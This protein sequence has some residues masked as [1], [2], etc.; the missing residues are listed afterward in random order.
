MASKDEIRKFHLEESNH[1]RRVAMRLHIDTFRDLIKES[2]VPTGI[3]NQLC[4]ISLNVI[5]EKDETPY[6][7]DI[8]DILLPEV[9]TEIDSMKK[10]AK[11]KEYFTLHTEVT[12]QVLYELME[13]YILL[14]KA[15][16]GEMLTDGA[17]KATENF[18][19]KHKLENI[20][21]KLFSK[22]E[23]ERIG[24]ENLDKLAAEF[25]RRVIDAL[26]AGEVK[27]VMGF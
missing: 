4:R 6:L 23:K 14:R 17:R 1:E 15:A 10:R 7:E 8:T 25:A 5:K 26:E 2:S 11:T 13:R 27:E 16:N 21:F 20:I 3:K 24:Q 22:E 18:V 12:K 19:L 9:I